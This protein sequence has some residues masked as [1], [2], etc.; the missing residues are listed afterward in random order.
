MSNAAVH[1]D[2]R[3]MQLL[4]DHSTE[5]LDV[6]THGEMQDLLREHPELSSDHFELAAASIDLAWSPPADV[7]L[8]ASLRER[9][10]ADAGQY[11]SIPD[12]VDIPLEF[13]TDVRPGRPDS[14]P[15]GMLSTLGWYLAAA[16]LV[17]AAIGWWRVLAPGASSEPSVAQAY[18]SFTEMATDLVRASWSGKEPGYETVAGEVIWSDERQAGFMKLVGLKPNDQEREQ[19][20]LWIVDPTR[21]EHPVDGGVFNV[22]S[23]G[24]VLVPIDAKL[25]VA[26][27]TVFAITLEQP[28]GVV[29]SDGPL[30]VV[31]A[32]TG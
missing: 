28:G 31:G 27:P 20:Q 10:I 8:P 9:I 11:L 19:Y 17:L 18:T 29:V 24:E 16:C 4:A 5:G 32:T 13:S 30:L 21:D 3:L 6:V 2:D 23:T 1:G 25:R 26:N 14:P 7:T 15:R 22:S 12:R